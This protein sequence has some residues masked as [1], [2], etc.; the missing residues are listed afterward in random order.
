MVYGPGQPP[1][2]TGHT[3]AWQVTAFN[4]TNPTYFQN[5]GKSEV[6]AFTYKQTIIN[7]ISDT[8][9]FVINL[10]SDTVR[11][12]G[13]LQYYYASEPDAEGTNTNINSTASATNYPFK[14][15][16]LRLIT[17]YML[18]YNGGAD[19]IY[20]PYNTE[21]LSQTDNDDVIANTTSSANG[22]F[23]FYFMTNNLPELGL[24]QSGVTVTIPDANLIDHYFNNAG[25][26][27]GG[28]YDFDLGDFGF[29]DGFG[30]EPEGGYTFETADDKDY[31]IDNDFDFGN[32]LNLNKN[33]RT[34]PEL[35]LGKGNT[36]ELG[37]GNTLDLGG[38]TNVVNYSGGGDGSD[39][40][41]GTFTGDLYRVLQVYVNNPYY[42]QPDNSFR[43]IADS[44]TTYVGAVR[45]RVR[46]YVLNVDIN[47][48]HNENGVSNYSNTSGG[49]TIPISDDLS[50]NDKTGGKYTMDLGGGFDADYFVTE[51]EYFYFEDEDDDKVFESQLP[52]DFEIDQTDESIS[53]LNGGLYRYS[54]YREI[55]PTELPNNEGMNLDGGYGAIYDVESGDMIKDLGEIGVLGA[56]DY[57]AGRTLISRVES[58]T[59]HAS[60]NK[61]IKSLDDDD[62]YIL[63]IE[64]V[65]NIYLSPAVEIQ[66]RY[67]YNNYNKEDKAVY[68][69][70]FTT[71]E[72][73]LDDTENTTLS[74]TA[75]V[76]G[77]INYKFD[78]PNIAEV[79]PL[80]NVDVT[81]QRLQ[82]VITEDGQKVYSRDRIDLITVTT[83]A[84]GKYL[85][86]YTD[87]AAYGLIAMEGMIFGEDNCSIDIPDEENMDF[88]GMDEMLPGYENINPGFENINPGIENINPGGN[89]NLNINKELNYAPEDDIIDISLPTAY[90]KSLP[91]RI[92]LYGAPS[93]DAVSAP[94]SYTGIL[95]QEL[96]IKIE[97]D[98]YTSPATHFTILPA[99]YKEVPDLLAYVR[100]YDLTITVKADPDVAVQYKVPNAALRDM[101]VVLI[102]KSKPTDVPENE[103][104][105][106]GIDNVAIAKLITNAEKLYNFTGTELHVNIDNGG[107]DGGGLY[108]GMEMVNIYEDFMYFGES[109]INQS[110][111]IGC[112]LVD[113]N[114]KITFKNLVKNIG[115]SD[116]YTL[117][118]IP[119]YENSDINYLIPQHT[120]KTDFNYNIV[121]PYG[122][123]A[124]TTTESLAREGYYPKMK[125]TYTMEAAPQN[126]IIFGKVLR[127]DNGFPLLDADVQLLDN[128]GEIVEMQTKTASD[129]TYFLTL[130]KEQYNSSSV[131]LFTRQLKF[132]KYGYDDTKTAYPIYLKKG[133]ILNR[134]ADT[135]Q[136]AVLVTGYIYTEWWNEN[137]STYPAA[138]S[139][140]Q[141]GNGPQVHTACQEQDFTLDLGAFTD[142]AESQHELDITVL[143]PNYE[144]MWEQ[145][146]WDPSIQV[147][148]NEN[149]YNEGYN[150]EFDV[151][152]IDMGGI[153]LGG[154]T[155][156]NRSG[157]MGTGIK[158]NTDFNKAAPD[159]FTNAKTT[160]L[161]IDT[162]TT[163][164]TTKGT[165]TTT[166][167][168]MNGTGTEYTGTGTSGIGTSGPSCDLAF[169]ATYASRGTW[170]AEINPDSSR[171]ITR[172]EN[173][174]IPDTGNVLRLDFI[175]Y[176][177]LHR[178]RVNVTDIYD[179]PVNAE[180]EVVGI[181]DALS[182]G[183]D[184]I[185]DILFE[186]SGN[187]FTLLING[188]DGSTFVQKE[189]VI[190]NEASE[191]MVNYDVVLLQ[192][193]SISG[194]VT[195]GTPP[196]ENARVFIDAAGMEYLETYTDANGNYTLKGV[197]KTSGF[198]VRAVKEGTGL[199]GD[200]HWVVTS[201]SSNITGVNFN[202]TN[203]AGMDISKL[204]GFKTEI[205][206]LS[207]SGGEVKI[208]GSLVDVADNSR[209]SMD[210]E[211][212]FPF[213]YVK[214]KASTTLNG[215]GVA[216][217][218]PVDASFTISNSDPL[219]ITMYD[220]YQA[221]A[222]II[223]A[224]CVVEKVNATSG[225][226]KSPVRIL[227]TTFTDPAFNFTGYGSTG[228]Y[229]KNKTGTGT[230]DMYYADISHDLITLFTTGTA[231][232]PTTD[233]YEIEIPYPGAKMSFNM[234]NVPS[235]PH[236][237]LQ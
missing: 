68:S 6:C 213:N 30:S 164:G 12:N 128:P 23:S 101:L 1:L 139:Y 202:L 200:S 137:T 46:D 119:D 49:T 25:A 204:L 194:K 111:I 173:V 174:Y 57:G 91:K 63:V 61:L 18:K 66:F 80:K 216:Y 155:F 11:I 206:Y 94:C 188:P 54:I 34:T 99:Q 120:F 36:L 198:T 83:D 16:P 88:P 93:P 177:K 191:F 104:I 56:K 41:S 103:G 42:C 211:V 44:T 167:G 156:T 169:Y 97:S 149:I 20:L 210:D 124:A 19:S 115:V 10:H 133:K 190:T 21:G 154:K 92:I 121:H 209:F 230:G 231:I 15:E 81:L 132:S 236:H 144:E 65:D 134:V 3:Y 233:Y 125:V 22:D 215:S 145:N 141:I 224:S 212:R 31:V 75:V 79:F 86:N 114:G 62:Y 102:R 45:S 70:Q 122:A 123:Y 84:Q 142:Y 55:T 89:F 143:I 51:N 221:Q 129:G 72:V 52:W 217:A 151:G 127:S 166:G 69:S 150:T 7:Y 77:I 24:V 207:T 205:E 229:L 126:P 178:L 220:E 43:N 183:T 60:F 227:E 39:P 218:E 4:A 67:E 5:D 98:Y 225:K 163:T 222:G 162:K 100:S 105:V 237:H 201:G 193:A 116:N 160:G 108:G 185:R 203:Y 172:F 148:Q 37:K 228:F 95:Y 159:G 47:T 17:K 219:A 76:T 158:I 78:D 157:D 184:G 9:T 85:F 161:T 197:P 26:G 71:L 13:N 2:E 135:L 152:G 175:V 171:Y 214:I 226:I 235:F 131:S 223:A 117:L 153:D 112:G 106:G 146:A 40:I 130:T 113:V 140:V 232:F 182:T 32:Y 48:I 90:G 53:Q 50:A 165:T 82:Y 107:G 74:G 87:T 73:D 180:V 189:L 27:S 179:N 8:G 187:T 109:T 29:I 168:V 58:S 96:G 118:A 14:N 33:L 199:I 181:T 176:Q 234:Q 147:F 208:S 59:G 136:P 64:P 138:T 28:D 186:N 195:N 192:G 35:D 196:V 110:D 170:L 38:T